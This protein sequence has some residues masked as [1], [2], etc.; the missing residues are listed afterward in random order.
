M[1]MMCIYIYIY[2]DKMGLNYTLVTDFYK[3]C[4][5][6][7]NI[8]IPRHF[9]HFSSKF[10]HNPKPSTLYPPRPRPFVCVYTV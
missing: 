7:Y 9:E 10:V 8:C 2:I 1:N 5:V 4:N 3:I 6:F